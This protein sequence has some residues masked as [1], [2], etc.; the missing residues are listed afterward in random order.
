MVWLSLVREE[1]SWWLDSA[2]RNLS[3]AQACGLGDCEASVFWAHQAV[4]HALKALIIHSGV[5]PP[6]THNL[7]T[8]Y[9]ILKGV[10]HLSSFEEQQLSELTPYY[11]ASRY[12]DVYGGEPKVHEETCKRFLRFAKDILGKIEENLAGNVKIINNLKQFEPSGNME[13][14]VND[15]V[16][17]LPIRVSRVYLFGSQVRGEEVETSDVDLLITSPDFEKIPI[18]TRISMVHPLWK[19]PTPADIVLLTDSEL[20]ALVDKSIVLKDASKYWR[21]LK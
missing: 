4:E 3:R 5:V 20:E 10:L 7:I 18:D 2:K 17:H 1:V 19:H 12:P 6:K 16:K 11:S 21:Q 15:F 13:F 14:L 9:A 8:L